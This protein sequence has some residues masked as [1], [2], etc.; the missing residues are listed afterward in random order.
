MRVKRRTRD[1]A[2][3]QSALEKGL[4]PLAAHV[5]AC[6]L[7]GGANGLEKIIRPRLQYI[8]HPERLKDAERA[9]RRIAA[10]VAGGERIGIAT[11][12]DTDGV[13][14]HAVIYRALTEYFGVPATRVD[15][16]I[17]HRMQDGYGVSDRLAAR[18]LAQSP[19]PSL[20]ITADCGSSDE[21]RLARL[22]QAGIDGVVTDHHVLPPDG[23]PLSAYAVVNPAQ[24]GCSYPDDTIAGCMVAW[25]LMSLVRA[26]L[27]AGGYLPP[28]APKLIDVLDYVGLGTVADCVG[29]DTAV[30]RA[31]V[32]A[33]LQLMNRSSRPCWRAIRTL[34]EQEDT[35]LS[36]DF[37]GFQLAPRINARSRLSDPYA[38]LRFLLAKTDREAL[39][40]LLM[41]EQDNQARR[42]IERTM[43]EA[44]KEEA[45]R[46]AAMGRVSLVVYLADGH[47]GVQGIVASRLAEAF[48][49][50]AVVLCPALEPA[51]LTGSARGVPGLHVRDALQRAADAHPGLFIKFG[52]HRGAPGLT[53]SA[54]KLPLL[55][56]SV[57]AAVRNWL[58]DEAV[59]PVVFTDGALPP[60]AISRETFLELEQLQPFGR[61]FD[62]P[63]FD[64][65]FRVESL[66][67]VGADGVHLAME[68]SNAGSVHKAIWFRALDAADS[69]MP[70]AEG[71]RIRCVYRLSLNTFRGVTRLQLLIRFAARDAAWNG[72]PLLDNGA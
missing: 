11:D 44:A 52:G 53:L 24:T 5:L 3:Y 62:P 16:F 21:P 7:S 30:N 6:R 20:V 2:V 70:V 33:G 12:Y 54:E 19:Q 39:E 25:L 66:R 45:A 26:Q 8:P 47:S 29:I 59:G 60:A 27:V 61:E 13:T 40:Y 14:S 42:Q 23:P 67:V 35:P 49:R 48:G 28:D 68:L 69:P 34:T 72:P 55:Q 50:P 10:A 46:Q 56:T 22:K 38:A 65:G 37:L 17:G 43:V 63:V 36:A 1:A 15:S 32:G 64:G 51:Q 9:A 71:D 58:D 41:L 4:P 57:E 18:I 31:V